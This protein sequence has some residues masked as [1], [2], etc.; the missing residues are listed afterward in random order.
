MRRPILRTAGHLE[1][2]VQRSIAQAAAPGHLRY[3]HQQLYY[4]LCRLLRPVPGLRTAPALLAGVAGL[5]PALLSRARRAAWLAAA[6]GALVGALWLA[7]NFPYTRPPPL[8]F[9]QFLDMLVNHS[10]SHGHPEG[11]LTPAEPVRLAPPAA[12]YDLLDYGL[13]R[14]LVC[15]SDEIAHM[16]R[17]NMSHM[18]MKC[19]ILGLSSATPLPDVLRPML[20]RTSEVSIFFLHDASAEGLALAL[21]LRDNLEL[22]EMLRHVEVTAVGLRPIHAMRLHLFASRGSPAAAQPAISPAWLPVLSWREQHWLR[23]G[24]K[25]DVAAVPPSDLLVKLRR[26]VG[27]RVPP[28]PDLMARLRNARQNGFMTWPVA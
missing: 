1:D 13:S 23:Q 18:E 27:G 28:H 3:T 22:N 17:A 16:L 21:S 26:I 4:E 24:W 14:V 8:S 25:A 6:D 11:L 5:V 10:A 7:R 15:Q 9:E 19:A 2:L 12:E 20:A